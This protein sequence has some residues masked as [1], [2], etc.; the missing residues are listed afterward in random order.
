MKVATCSQGEPHFGH[1]SL[2]PPLLPPPPLLGDPWVTR[3][4]QIFSP[5]SCLNQPCHLSYHC[6]HLPLCHH[7][8]GKYFSIRQ[9]RRED[10]QIV[11]L[12]INWEIFGQCYLVCC[13][14]CAA[15]QPF[16]LLRGIGEKI[17]DWSNLTGTCVW[18][19]GVQVA[20]A[21]ESSPPSAAR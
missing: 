4:Y 17:H 19:D 2:S 9:K 1:S 11:H 8:P 18:I 10:K 12:K 5:Q 16:A 14:H 20:A 7:H 21:D 3:F 13:H 6:Q 15:G